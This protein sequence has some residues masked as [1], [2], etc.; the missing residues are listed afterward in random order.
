M[1]MF[2]LL[3]AGRIVQ[4]DYA[5]V[6]EKHFLI[7]IPDADNIHHVAVFLT[8][9]VA[10][11]PGFSGLMLFAVYYSLP[12]PNAPPN[13]RLMGFISNE[14]PSSIFRISGLKIDD[15]PSSGFLQFAQHKISHVAQIG[16]AI[17]TD[18]VV[19]QQVSLLESESAKMQCEVVAYTQKMLENFM[20]YAM[21][22]VVSPN[23]NESYVPMNVVENWYKNFERR[24]QISPFFWKQP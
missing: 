16:I 13:W 15:P 8:G 6:D 17:D 24:L 19:K 23:P 1:A 10:F 2:G 5:M 7:T 21:S 3:V 11:P 14:K 12:D 22:F 18:E 20:N 4:T 9:T